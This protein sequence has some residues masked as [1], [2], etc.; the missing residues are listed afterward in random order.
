MEVEPRNIIISMAF[1]HFNDSPILYSNKQIMLRDGV[2][3]IQLDYV[4]NVIN[5]LP[6]LYLQFVKQFNDH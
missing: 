5:K 2:R 1:K 6:I 3:N 4:L